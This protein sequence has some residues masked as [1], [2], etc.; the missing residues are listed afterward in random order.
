MAHAEAYPA[1]DMST[2][3]GVLEEALRGGRVQHP[4]GSWREVKAN[5]S[6]QHSRALNE[7]VRFRR[8]ELVVEVGMAYGVSTL[9][10][11][12]ALQSTG[13]G[14]LISIDPYI[15]WPSGRL[16]ALHQIKR[17]GVGDFHK[18]M[19]ECSHTALPKLLMQG[20][21]PDFIYI[22]GWHN[23][24]CV[25]TDC[26]FA[27]K[28]LKPGGAV[29]F[30]DAGWRPVFKV[31]RFLK[32]YRKYRELDVGLPKRYGARNRLFEVIKRLEGR[33]SCDRYFEKVEE[34]EPPSGFHR[35]F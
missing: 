29:A 17:A 12:D 23:F 27:D 24:D 34:W 26:F 10:I 1:P 14:R 28:L 3:S 25:F 13:K 4:D 21:Q 6:V 19:C 16:V 9:T 20:H 35:W 8:P 15:D 33:S 22:D 31:I 5:I 32:A 30:N 7:F 2:V 18:H 11:L